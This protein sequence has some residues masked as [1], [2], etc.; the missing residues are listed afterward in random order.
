MFANYMSHKVLTS[1][2][3]KET[4]NSVKTEKIQYKIG[5]T[6]LIDPSKQDSQ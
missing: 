3:Y 5:K 1:K 2:M 4:Y 6:I